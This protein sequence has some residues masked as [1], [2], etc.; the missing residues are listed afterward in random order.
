MK[1][2][3]YI[4]YENLDNNYSITLPNPTDVNVYV[5]GD[6]V[7]TFSGLKKLEIVKVPTSTNNLNFNFYQVITVPV[8]ING[9]VKMVPTNMVSTVNTAYLGA[10]IDGVE[11]VDGELKVTTLSQD[12]D[13]DEWM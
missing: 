11:Y 9:S 12:K 6:K 8:P 13:D 1:K 5:D 7:G 2:R 4:D 10:C 3:I